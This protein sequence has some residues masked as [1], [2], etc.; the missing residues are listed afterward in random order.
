MGSLYVTLV[1]LELELC[2]T[3]WPQ[4]DRSACLCLVLRLKVC[5]QCLMVTLVAPVLP[6][7]FRLRTAFFRLFKSA[8]GVI[9]IHASIFPPRRKRK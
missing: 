8:T 2:R 4:I 9:Y 7:F 1:G 6:L 3:D 5:A